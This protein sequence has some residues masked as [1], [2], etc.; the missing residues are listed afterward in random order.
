MHER[1][2]RG[3]GI[4][5]SSKGLL[6]LLLVVFSVPIATRIFPICLTCGIASLEP[7]T[8]YR[9]WLIILEIGI[10]FFLLVWDALNLDNDP[11]VR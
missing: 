5:M 2:E 8:S 10:G 6:G 7:E 11:D 4:F 1:N 3:P 9:A